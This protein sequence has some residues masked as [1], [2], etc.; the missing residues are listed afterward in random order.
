MKKIYYSALALLV[1]GMSI[2]TLQAQNSVSFDTSAT[3]NGYMNVFDLGGGYQ[4]GN[5]WGLGDLKSTIDSSCNTLTLQ[6]NFNVY[7]STDAYYTD[8]VTFD[9]AKMMEANTYVESSTL[10]NGSDL[11]FSGYVASNTL[12]AGYTAEYFIKALDPANGWQ[13]ALGGSAMI[14]LPAS[15]NFTVSVTGASLTAGLVVQ[16]GFKIYGLNANPA[17]E[18]ALGSVVVT[19][20]VCNIGTSISGTNASVFGA[21]D[22]EATVTTSCGQGNLTYLWSNGSASNSA[23]GLAAGAYDVTITDDVAAGC[24]AA[25]SITITEPLAGC[26]ITAAVSG[27]SVT[28]N[29]GSDGSASV[30]TTGG[31]GVITYMWSNGASTASITGL[32][33]GTYSVTVMDDVIAGCRTS[34][35]VTII[36]PAGVSCTLSGYI[37]PSNNVTTAG[38]SDGMAV[39]VATGDQGNVT[40]LWSNSATTAAINNLTAGVYTVTIT[41]D[42]TANCDFIVSTTITEPTVN[43]TSGQIEGTWKLRPIAYSLAVG[44]APG[45]YNWWG[46]SDSDVIV[47]SC[48]YDDEYVFNTDGSFENIVGIDTWLESW[49]GQDP[50]GCG[51][52]VAPHD[53]SNAATWTID[54][55]AGNVTI[56]GLGAYLGLAKVHNTGEDGMPMNNEITYNY[57]LEADSLD[58]TIQGFNP[59]VPDAEWL[60]RLIRNV[61]TGSNGITDMIETNSFKLYPNPSKDNITIKSTKTIDYIV[62]R[63][64]LG[65]NVFE[66]DNSINNI[67]S[68]SLENFTSDVYFV[69][70]HSN[71]VSETKKLVV[72]N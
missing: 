25:E 27:T 39:A 35:S 15:G 38:G 57:S 40:Y 32:V 54:S 61:D 64:I 29:G 65:R 14:S 21:S 26:S 41:D 37:S 56:N 66:Q 31:Q 12:A 34:S 59:G 48:L 43:P 53:G 30:S 72:I 16:Y 2:V 52:P 62:I 50:E 7:D 28:N 6:P 67:L 42:T 58:I 49:Q 44:E 47:R 63:D 51:A 18:A 9:G 13:D 60:F 24:A 20:G 8:P 45:N 1:A 55:V 10:F 69:E 22:G 5:P 19:N 70:V 17:N 3:W 4:F 68:V 71:G 11:T 46:I 36:E 33:A 23:T